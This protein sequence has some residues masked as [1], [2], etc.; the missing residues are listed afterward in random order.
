MVMDRLS[1]IDSRLESM[2]SDTEM[3]MVFSALQAELRSGQRRLWFI[4]VPLFVV[5]FALLGLIYFNR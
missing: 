5:N 1:A 3:A 4:L 2:P